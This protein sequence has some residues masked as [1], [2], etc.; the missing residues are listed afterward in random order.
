METTTKFLILEAR[1]INDMD[2]EIFQ[3]IRSLSQKYFK[4]TH[5]CKY[6]TERVYALA[7]KIGKKEVADLVV[8]KASALLHDLARSLEDDNKIDDHAIEG[9][10]I[11]R[12]ILKKSNFYPEKINDVLHCIKV[13]RYSKD[14]K[15]ESLEAKILQDADRLDM[16]G[17]IGLARVFSKTGALNNPIHDPSLH[18]K[19]KY[20]GI[21]L[22]AINHIY[23]KLLKSKNK[24]H[25]AS[26]KKMSKKRYEFVEEFL[27]IFLKEWIG[28]D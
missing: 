7:V 15:P 19:Q 28:E 20:D 17:A 8:I 27:K 1:S 23:E 25:T 12:G 16:I 13:H 3:K 10:K 6:H 11:A 5:H 22:T 24:F 14:L 26:A 21:S 4:H 18:P 9:V 2:E